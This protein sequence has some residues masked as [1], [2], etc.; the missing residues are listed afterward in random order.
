MKIDWRAVSH[1]GGAIVGAIVP[2]VATLENAA[3]T[4]GG[5]KGREK[6]DAVVKMALA[7]LGVTNTVAG[8]ELAQDADV[9]KA[10]R[11]VIDAVV[12]LNTILAKK[13]AAAAA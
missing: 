12:A 4:V 6:Q 1:I 5:M 10:T 11:G 7:A 13:A 9:E 2:G 3:W 8:R